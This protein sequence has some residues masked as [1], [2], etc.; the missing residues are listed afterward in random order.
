MATVV[1]SVL[2]ILV[3]LIATYC[4]CA[5]A[6]EL[7]CSLYELWS[8]LNEGIQNTICSTFLGVLVIGVVVALAIISQH[9]GWGL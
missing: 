7:G 4:A 1:L 3:A 5:C 9:F 8:E 6:C 2:S